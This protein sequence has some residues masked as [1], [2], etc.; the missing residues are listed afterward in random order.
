[1]MKLS[2]PNRIRGLGLGAGVYTRAFAM[3]A[4]GSRTAPRVASVPG[5][6]VRTQ[7]ILRLPLPFI[8]G[9]SGKEMCSGWLP[10]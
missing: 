10:E 2:N 5:H 6:S 8:A 7:L 1:M 9:K 4:R 3:G